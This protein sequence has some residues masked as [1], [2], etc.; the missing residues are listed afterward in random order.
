MSLYGGIDSCWY[1]G[2]HRIKERSLKTILTYT[3]LTFLL[4]LCNMS[5]L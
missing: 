4:F 5:R 1:E 3:V 2:L